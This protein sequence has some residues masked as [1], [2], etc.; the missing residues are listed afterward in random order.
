M[1]KMI[2]RAEVV[3]GICVMSP[4]ALLSCHEN[5]RARCEDECMSAYGELCGGSLSVA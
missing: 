1:R 5:Q 3:V 2:M 4:A